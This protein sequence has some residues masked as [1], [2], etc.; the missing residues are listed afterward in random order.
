MEN[1][2]E[3]FSYSKTRIALIMFLSMVLILFFTILGGRVFGKI[4]E[5]IGGC[6]GILFCFVNWFITPKY[7]AKSVVE[8]YYDNA[9]I[10]ITCVKPFFGSKIN[11]I[12]SIKYDELKSYK[13]EATSNF[14]TFKITLK[15]GAKYKLHRWY[16]DNDDQFDEFFTKFKKNIKI[17]DNKKS[18][19]ERIEKEKSIL[20]NRFFFISVAI[21]LFLVFLTT[22][23]LLFTRGIQN[24]S[25]II[26]IFIFLAPLIWVS[27]QIIKGLK[28]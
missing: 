18:S 9:G 6:F 7:F 22:I 19:L 28:K 5:Y 16:N 24:K 2:F 13:F 8:I 20:E 15:D 27:L 3:I 25:G 26:F 17:Y 21:I 23:I 4:G 11:K 10:E 14:S 12:I 1:R